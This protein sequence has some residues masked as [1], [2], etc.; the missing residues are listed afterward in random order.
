MNLLRVY[1][2]R[3][4]QSNVRVDY[5]RKTIRSSVHRRLFDDES[6][7]QPQNTN[8]LDTNL[9]RQKRGPLGTAMT[10]FATKSCPLDESHLHTLPVNLVQKIFLVIFIMRK[11]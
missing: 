1:P 8:T 9:Y 5:G 3:N 4:F 10:A 7:T 2:K 6:E 11:L